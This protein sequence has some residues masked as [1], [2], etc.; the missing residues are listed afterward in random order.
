MLWN[1]CDCW[2]VRILL[3]KVAT[4]FDK[5]KFGV[6]RFSGKK[7]TPTSDPLDSVVYIDAPM[8][9]NKELVKS[10]IS[11][12]NPSGWT[13]TPDGIKLAGQELIANG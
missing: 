8:S 2:C 5:P 13:P 7:T 12:A 6:S 4:E 10:Q 11:R 9:L 1:F 3:F